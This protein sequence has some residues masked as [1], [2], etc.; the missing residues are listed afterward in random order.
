M[1]LFRPIPGPRLVIGAFGT[2]DTPDCSAPRC[3]WREH[4]STRELPARH[5]LGAHHA[6]G[7]ARRSRRRPIPAVQS[8]HEPAGCLARR[9]LYCGSVGRA[10][11]GAFSVIV[12]PVSTGHGP[13]WTADGMRALFPALVGWVLTGRSFGLLVPLGS[14]TAE[15]LLG[16]E[17]GTPPSP[18]RGQ[19]GVS[20]AEL[21]PIA[22]TSPTSAS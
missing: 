9:S 12:L 14:W 4:R 5:S 11:L 18:P 21:E 22:S 8:A 15:R 6:G 17:P 2:H 13:Q 1:S 16:P 3:A 10:V 20:P 7:G 19:V